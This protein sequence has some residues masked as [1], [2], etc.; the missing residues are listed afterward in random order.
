MESG[1]IG[2]SQAKTTLT[3]NSTGILGDV[4]LPSTTTSKGLCGECGHISTTI[5]INSSTVGHCDSLGE[6][7]KLLMQKY[8]NDPKF[9][10]RYAW[11]NSADPDQTSDLIRVF[12]VCRSVFIVW[13]HYSMVEPHSSNFRVTTT[14]IL[15]VRNVRIFMV[16][17]KFYSSTL[18]VASQSF[19][20][21][22]L[23]PTTYA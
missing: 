19:K 15:G 6:L 20:L 8:R 16:H 10:H 1:R 2:I 23:R 9:S 4:T 12:T 3:W 18:S 17:L 22:T 7:F 14:N 5:T 11:A 21:E 13:T